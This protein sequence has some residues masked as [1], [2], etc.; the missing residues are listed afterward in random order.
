MRKDDFSGEIIIDRIWPSV[1]HGAIPARGQHNFQQEIRCRIFSHGTDMIRGQLN[2]LEPGSGRWKKVQMKRGEN[3]FYS[4]FIKLGY[5]GTYRF[6]IEAWFDDIATWFRNLEKWKDSGEDISQ[7]I[8]AGIA[9]FK[10]IR[11]NATERDAGKIDAVMAKLKEKRDFQ[12]NQ[13]DAI[14]NL[15]LK[16]QDRRS[17]TRSE[18]YE[19]NSIGRKAYFGSW[20]EMFPRSQS[21]VPGKTGTFRDCIKRL[22]DIKEMGFDVIYFP[23]IHPIGKTNR[24]GKNG[25][26]PASQGDTG[27]PWAIGNIHGG[28]NAIN[29]DLGTMEDFRELV[30]A[31][32]KEGISIALDIA[33]QCSPDHPYVREHPE[34]F[35]RRPD[36]SIRYAENPPKKYFDIYPLNFRCEN[37]KE[38]W[39][40]ILG[41]FEF[42]IGAGIRIFR[43]D[44]PHTKPLNFWKW[45]I[46]SINSRYPDVVFLSEAF[47]KPSVM[48]QLSKFGFQQSYTYFTWKNYDYE[49]RD[50]F[51]ELNS[52]QV[53]AFFQPMLFTNTP[54][55]LPFTLQ[56][57]GR[58]AFIL[59]AV[60]AA[61]LSPL[62]GIYSGFELCENTA[63][64]GTEE[65]LDSEKFQ[66]RQ[67]DWRG[68]GNIREIIGKLNEIREKV[69]NF[70]KHGNVKFINTGNHNILAYVRT[71]R[72]SASILIIVNINPFEIHSSSVS[73]PED[74]LDDDRKEFPVRD[75]VTGESMVWSKG[76]NMVKLVP[77]Y[78]C[79]MILSKVDK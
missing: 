28:H 66:L 14:G 35:Y 69:L 40:E 57:G 3:D 65:Y 2:Y 52:P 45:L 11:K 22:P 64:P 58:A 13:M 7:D 70:Q 17:R 29:P 71:L 6:Y 12:K 9:L 49:I 55:I 48:Y 79:A 37:W 19:I 68:P 32:S 10:E 18:K 26:M 38:L 31:A 4:V 5:E 59:R 75:L 47:T 78:R 16:Y 67:R 62:W 51:T 44:N 20:Y 33:L 24:R 42:W 1:D 63:I 72:D 61:T 25:A 41:I 77:E 53:S 8:E 23:P 46:S 21:S 56:N 74:W 76:N 36:G 50:Y 43:V 39:D 54:D 15:I 30:S 73:T 27:S 34:W 60:L